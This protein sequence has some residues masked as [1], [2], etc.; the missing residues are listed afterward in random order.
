VGGKWNTYVITARGPTITVELN[1]VK[2][3]ELQ[4]SKFASGP[5]A[6]QYG[7]TPAARSV[8]ESHHQAAVAHKLRMDPGS[9]RTRVRS[10]MTIGCHS[11]VHCTRIRIHFEPEWIRIAREY[12]TTVGVIL[13]VHCTQHPESILILERSRLRLRFS[14]TS[15]VARR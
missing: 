12:R 5:V 3:V 4:D 8:P 15:R 9:I 11:G 13:E 1:G 14:P 10:R 7:S 2:T 6:L